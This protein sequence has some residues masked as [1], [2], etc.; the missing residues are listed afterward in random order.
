MKWWIG[1]LIL[2]VM[3][4]GTASAEPEKVTLDTV[5]VTAG[6]QTEKVSAVPAHVTVIDARIIA[7]SSAQNL[8]ELLQEQGIHVSDVGGAGRSY[9]VDLR[10]FGESAPAN[11][12]VLVDG[13]RIN[14]PDLAGADWVLIPLERIDRVEII[15]GGRG[16]VLYGDN[17]SGGVIN[18]ITKEATRTGGAVKTQYGSYE[19]FK[20][21]AWA[22]V[23]GE[24]WSM[25]LSGG[26][27]D[28][29]GYR[30]NSATEMKDLGLNLRYD[31]TDRLNLYLNSGFHNDRS[32]LPGHLTEHDLAAGHDR[33]DT[34]Y[35]DDFADTEDYYVQ[36][37]MD[38]GIF[39]NETIKLD[40]SYRRRDKTFKLFFS[41]SSY[42]YTTVMETVELSP[43]LVLRHDLGPMANRLLLGFDFADTEEDIS[44]GYT[45]GKESGAYYFHDELTLLPGLTLSG[46]YRKDR[47]R[48]T[49]E[50]SDPDDKIFTQEVYD[51][52]INYAYGQGSHLYGSYAKSY[53]YPLLDEMFLFSAGT[54]DTE[55]RNQTSDH[56]EIG[57]RHM[58]TTEWSVGLA[59]FHIRTEDEIF[60]DKLNWAN[61]N[62]D[63]QT[64]RTGAE[65]ESAWRGRHLGVGAKY[66]YLR[67][68]IHGGDYDG[69]DVPDVPTHLGSAWVDYT[70]DFG[71]FV[72]LNGR[73]VGERP[74]IS[75][76]DNTLPDQDAYGVLDAKIKYP[77]RFLTFFVDLNN[78][79]DKEYSAFGGNDNPGGPEARAYYPSPEFNWMAGVSASF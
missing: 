39:D 16:S 68:K 26:Y 34:M 63:G 6:R 74:F 41:G 50:P 42:E 19:T 11:T 5:V 55:L 51:G 37:G 14:Q 77:Y 2:W 38:L 60:Y 57:A 40:S 64:R 45:L 53:R 44:G 29:D 13:R 62:L 9:W 4:P 71:L 75:D 25:D 69:M 36:A 10:G 46:G 1:L 52:G 24:R 31:A 54:I 67:A 47:A 30:D 33:T 49:F 27:S 78:I 17:A 72:G 28:S 12:L 20:T 43:Q 15:R 59:L 79:F 35:P 32:G 22:G 56:Y 58:L 18:I 70:F 7:D 65:I 66:T 23:V 73:Y 8:P 3:L 76:F 21:S 61:T 48:Y